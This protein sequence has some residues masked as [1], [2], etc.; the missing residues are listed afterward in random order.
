MTL[1]LNQNVTI[2]GFSPV[3]IILY[4]VECHFKIIFLNLTSHLSLRILQNKSLSEFESNLSEY[5]SK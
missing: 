3:I 4:Y 1:D 5:P 2:Y